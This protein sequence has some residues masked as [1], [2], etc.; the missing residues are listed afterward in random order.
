MPAIER[1]TPRHGPC[2]F[3]TRR[4][5]SI[6]VTYARSLFVALALA[7]A[8]PLAS[9]QPATWTIDPGHSSATFSVRHM[10]VAN[11][12]G[13][14]AGPVGTATYDPKDPST[15]RVEATIDARTINTRNP[16]RDKDLR[17]DLFFDVAKYPRITFKSKSVTVEGPGK[18]KVL[19]DLTIKGV[20]KSVTLEVEGPT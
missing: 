1:Y 6:P 2:S 7:A 15:L 3:T 18:L 19:G 16:D 10:V 11:V 4:R 8:P 13:E 20:T 5:P 9:A 14:F 12:K 17:S